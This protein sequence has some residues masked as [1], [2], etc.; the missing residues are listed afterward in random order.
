MNELRK[1][2]LL[3]RWV[4]IAG[5]RGKRPV[6]FIQKECETKEGVCVFCPGN[7]HLTPKEILSILGPHGW[8][9]RAFENMY[10]ATSLEFPQAFGRH[11]V[12]VEMNQHNKNLQ[13]LPPGAI[14]EVI[15]MYCS[16]I[17]DIS[18]IDGIAYVLIFKNH[19]E[20]AGTSIAH[21]HSQLIALSQIPTLVENELAAYKKYHHK[22]K[23]CIFCDIAE[24]EMNSERKIFENDKF[25]CFAPFASRFPF[26][27]WLLPKRHAGNITDLTDEEKN[28]LADA[29]KTIL[30]ALSKLLRNPPYNYYLHIAPPR[31]DFHFHIEICPRV[32][33]LAGFE[34][35]SDIIINTMPPEKAAAELKALL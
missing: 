8:T 10:P 12:I 7:E 33:K 34:L 15:D 32:T 2:C 4:I 23:K 22:T 27:A 19:G 1:D 9:V 25:F 5:N 18:K 11:E 13:D 21:E 35:G 20:A 16:R 26:E 30:G 24:M 29:L 28:S 3:D 17:D 14:R 6:D 31:E